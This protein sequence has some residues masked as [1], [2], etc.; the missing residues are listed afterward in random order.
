MAPHTQARRQACRDLGEVSIRAEVLAGLSA[1]PR[2]LPPK[3]FYDERGARLFE[4]ISDLPEY[5]PTRTELSILRARAADIAR[6]SGPRSALVEYG[7]GAGI[8]VRLLLDALED[9]VAYVPVDISREQLDSVSNRLDASYPGLEVLPVHADY[10]TRFTL[11]PLPESAKRIAFFPGSTI[12]NF[13]PAEATA[14]LQRIRS[15]VGPDGALVL[16]VDRKK[17][18]RVLH[19]AYND[20]EGIT[21]AFNLNMLTRINRELDA[22]F[23]VD[24]FRH[25]AFFN[26]TAGRIEMH[27]ESLA[28][29]TVEVAGTVIEFEAG[30]TILTECSY[31]YDRDRLE[32]LV[33]AAGF[34]IRELWSDS[35][36]WFWVAFLEPA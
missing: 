28:N 6:L 24:R 30:E 3:L 32:G 16:G 2:T 29:Q 22:T 1:T 33:E 23:D 9:P 18:A 31:K 15:V 10:T 19:D 25:H 7:S 12:G 36:D 8:K 13:H 14:F 20:A 5:Y 17:D 11:P 34:R 27:L 26:E 4:A 21:A 35:C